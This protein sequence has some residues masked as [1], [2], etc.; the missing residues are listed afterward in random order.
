MELT[1]YKLAH[2]KNA[3]S[4]PQC[5][6]GEP[7]RAISREKWSRRRRRRRMPKMGKRSNWVQQ[8]QR[9]LLRLGRRLRLQT[10]TDGRG[11]KRDFDFSIFLPKF[12]REGG[13]AIK[14][15]LL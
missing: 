12:R 3:V 13:E 4:I 14:E 9:S 1:I 8:L 11:R 7:C 6:F 10:E 2:V 15:R 5:I